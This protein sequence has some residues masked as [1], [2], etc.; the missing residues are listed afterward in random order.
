[1]RYNPSEIKVQ[2]G[3]NLR[4]TLINHGDTEHNIEF[5]LPDGEEELENNVQP[6]EQASLEFQAPEEA[7]T[8]TFYCPV[9]D[10]RERGM[11]GQLIVE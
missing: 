2:P 5:E 10:H 7:G 3:Q 11:T 4:I 8:Y 9:D 1:M 6:G